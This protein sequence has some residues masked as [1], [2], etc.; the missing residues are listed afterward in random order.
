M[1]RSAAANASASPHSSPK[2]T[3]DSPQQPQQKRRRIDS[4]SSPSTPTAQSDLDRINLAL[5]EEEKKRQDALARQAHDAGETKWVMDYARNGS[6]NG[7]AKDGGTRKVV[8]STTYSGLDAVED[9]MSGNRAPND[10]GRRSFG[11]FNKEVEVCILSFSEVSVVMIGNMAYEMLQ[12]ANRKQNPDDSTSGSD[13]SDSDSEGDNEDPS[14]V[15]IREVARSDFSSGKSSRQGRP[16]GPG[17]RHLQQAYDDETEKLVAA[18]REERRTVKRG[19]ISEGGGDEGPKDKKKRKKSK[20][21]KNT[22]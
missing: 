17:T 9:G 19:R 20:S 1:Q 14:V 5:A 3:P 7:T 15:A 18:R 11:R 13:D 12:K 16:S 2:A 10:L 21:K 22:R 8:V 4:Q 6:S